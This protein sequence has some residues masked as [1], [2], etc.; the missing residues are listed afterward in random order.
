ML[1]KLRLRIAFERL[2]ARLGR[3][4]NNLNGEQLMAFVFSKEGS[5]IEP[6]QF[7]E[8]LSQLLKLYE[9]KKFKTVLEIGTANGGMLFLHARLA[10]DDA[11]IMSI[12][13]PGGKFGGGY[14]E[15]K[16]PVY[17]KFIRPGQR[18]E[19]LRANSHEESTVNKVKEILKGKK[20]D[21]LFIDGDHTYEGV[22]KDFQMYSELVGSG[23]MIV[24]HDI[25]PHPKSSCVVDQFWNEVKQNFTFKEFI[26]QPIE[27]K[28]GIGVLFKQ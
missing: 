9:G 24:F 19:L 16:V 14:P 2:K 20:L 17:K 3:L 15:W 8:E 5:L 28:F 21:Y 10:A 26:K 23:G 1:N 11:L 27:N 4:P 12:D 6:W 13:L 25:A 7:K 22:K 18:I